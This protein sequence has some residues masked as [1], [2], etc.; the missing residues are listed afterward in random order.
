MQMRPEVQIKSMVKAMTD[1][2]LPAIDPANK[3]AQEQARL[4]VGMLS[5]MAQQLPLQFRF[6]CDEL[7]RL[8][9]L[10]AALEQASSRAPEVQVCVLEMN[11][12]AMVAAATL[13]LAQVGPEQVKEAVRTLRGTTSLVVRAVCNA[14]DGRAMQQVQDA[15]LAASKEQFLRDRSWVLMQGWEPDP[16][17]IPRIQDLL[18]AA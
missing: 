9:R 15:V 2:V 13:E 12:A 1:V 14:T 17:A 4:V 10:A 8:L 7:A 5:L 6:D 11:Q 18:R 16:A 3:L